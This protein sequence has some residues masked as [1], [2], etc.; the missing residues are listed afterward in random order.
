[1]YESL[2]NTVT[3]FPRLYSSSG[4][5]RVCGYISPLFENAGLIICPNLHRNCE[6]GE[7]G[8]GIENVIED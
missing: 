8:G 5:T 6:C 4:A 7:G 1:M 3:F 2:S